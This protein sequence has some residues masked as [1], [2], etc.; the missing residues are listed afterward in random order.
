MSINLEIRRY[1]GADRH[2]HDYSQVLFPLRGAMR[3]DIEGRTEVVA[4]NCVALIPRD[5]VHDFAPTPDCRFMVV[6]V[7]VAALPEERLPALLR[8]GEPSL[9]RLDPWLWR[10]FRLL[11][12]EVEADG[13]RAREAVHLVMSG[14]QLVRPGEALRPRRKAE[15]RILGVAC[16]YG[17]GS[18]GGSVGDAARAAGL[19]QSQFHALFRATVGL[20]PK[21]YRLA[22]LF[23]RAVD[24]LVET[25]DPISAIAYDLGYQDVSSFNRQFRQRFGMTPSQLRR[26]DRPAPGG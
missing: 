14:L 20:S 1:G 25:A 7:D 19:G 15:Q 23:G 3:V 6:D 8:A 4:S 9:T 2:V 26:G 5:H 17:E 22:K 10:L 11:G 24:R 13:Q 12:D 16:A 18:E 21:Q